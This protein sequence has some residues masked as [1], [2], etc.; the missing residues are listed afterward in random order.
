MKTYTNDPGAGHGGE[1]G[2]AFVMAMVF[3]ATLSMLVAAVVVAVTTRAPVVYQDASWQEAR[4]AAEAGIANVLDYMNGNITAVSSGT[5]SWPGWKTSDGGSQVLQSGSSLAMLGSANLT[6]NI[7]GT[8]A[9]I[10]SGTNLVGSGGTS[11]YINMTVQ[12]IYPTINSNAG[13]A[14]YRIRA[15]GT[16]PVGGKGVTGMDRMDNDLRR[17]TLYDPHP[18]LLNQ[19]PGVSWSGGGN[20]SLSGSSYPPW[21]PSSNTSTTTRLATASRVVEV[22]AAPVYFNPFTWALYTQ[23]TMSLANSNNFYVASYNSNYT[24]GLLPSGTPQTNLDNS[25]NT[26]WHYNANVGTNSTTPTDITTSNYNGYPEVYGGV[27]DSLTPA[28][29]SVDNP[30]NFKTGATTQSNISMT[31]MPIPDTTGYT[32]MK[33]NQSTI[34]ANPNK[35]SFVVANFDPGS[36]Q[37]TGS[38]NVT[39]VINHDWDVGSNNGFNSVFYVIVPS[40]VKAT[41]YAAGNI[42]FRNGNIN[43]S[44]SVVGGNGK[45][46]AYTSSGVAG[47]LVIYGC[48]PMGSYLNMKGNPYVVCAFYGP[49]Y[50]INLNGGGN[51]ALI[52]SFLGNTIE[53]NGGGASSFYYDEA[54]SSLSN[55]TIS[56]YKL[57]NYFEDNRL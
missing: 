14:W 25:N 7:S 3:L 31:T 16:A 18:T 54:L 22:L 24:G 48:G 4:M 20:W 37:F 45:T 26:A 32:V 57:S 15:M 28:T 42:T 40:S 46:T 23:S 50:D 1:R 34:N 21:W 6:T 2:S 8:S 19:V 44:F 36:I 43:E 55:I 5:A 35:N 47:N 29:T 41:I 9:L 49:N 17:L 39:L 30:T 51:G 52:G 27:Y 13:P 33:S 56:G 10:Y 53:F 38:G 11:A 12:A